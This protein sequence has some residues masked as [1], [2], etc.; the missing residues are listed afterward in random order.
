[1][2]AV[3]PTSAAVLLTAL[4]MMTAGSVVHGSPSEQ[5]LP[6]SWSDCSELVYRVMPHGLTVVLTVLAYCHFV[7]L[8]HDSPLKLTK[9]S[10]RLQPIQLKIGHNYNVTASFELGQ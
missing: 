3:Q 10:V 6:F 8:M 2:T 9:S 1:M 4:L 7:A 5:D